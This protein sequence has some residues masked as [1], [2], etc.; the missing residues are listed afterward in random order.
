MNNN[1]RHYFGFTKEPFSQQIA[2]KDI[3]PRPGL[4]GLKERFVYAVELGAVNVITGEIG[5]GKSTSMRYVID[6]SLHPSRYKVIYVIANTGSIT[7]ILRLI[8][9][10]LDIELCSNSITKLAKIVKLHLQ[11]FADK[12]QVPVLI[13]DEAHLLRVD[14]FAHLHTILQF[15]FDSRPIVPLMLCGQNCLVDKLRFHTSKPLASRVVGRTLLE[16]LKLKDMQSYL[17]HHLNIAGIK[18]HLFSDDAVLAIHQGSGGLL[19]TANILARGA[20]ISA[21]VNQ[22][23]TVSADDVRI[24]S[25]EI[26]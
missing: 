4:D 2:I 13:I 10:G 1:Y 11:E 15:D 23:K 3:Y 12:K 7:E 17:N 19:R 8:T 14:V 21:C 25:T 24:A 5:S 22:N 18:D 6:S 16:G 20:L 26:I 9:L